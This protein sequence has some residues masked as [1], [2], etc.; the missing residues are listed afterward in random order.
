MIFVGEIKE[1]FKKKDIK[2]LE[3]LCALL[4]TIEIYYNGDDIPLA[5]IT[6]AVHKFAGTV[7]EIMY[8]GMRPCEYRVVYKD[9][10]YYLDVLREEIRE[11]ES[12]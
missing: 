4:K 6:K 10:E 5:E 12:W 1:A 9:K 11:R 7:M 3:A 8:V 2:N